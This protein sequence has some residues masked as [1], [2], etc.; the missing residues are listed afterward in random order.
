[1]RS[2][3]F[4]A[5]SFLSITS[6]AQ[7]K[8]V[9]FS[10][11]DLPV[12]SYG[13]TDT[14]FQK[15]LTHK[16]VASLKAHKIPAVGFVNETKVYNTEGLNSFQVRLLEH[17]AGQGLELGNHTFSHRDY[18]NLSFKEFSQDVLK[19]E[20]VTKQVLDRHGRTMRYFRHPFLHAGDSKAKSDSLTNFLTDHGY[21]IAP[22]TLDNEEYL[23]A[24]AYKRAGDKNDKALQLRIGQDYL[25][26]M[27]KK[28]EYFERQARAL[29]GRDIAHVLLIHANALNADHMDALARMF[30]KHAYDFVSMEKA[31]EDKAYKTEVTVFG[32][33]GISWIDRWA[34]SQG[35]KGGFFKDEPET[36][37]YVKKLAE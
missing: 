30:E 16:L 2:L 22:V 1:M 5:A 29:F 32:K 36:P 26:Y 23:F 24:L 20:I 7:R 25:L 18:N 13:I 12:V 17:W 27:E 34:L 31:L 11:D 10:I 6:F 8:Q 33:W 19:G 21:T 35:K 28:L 14:S 9:C 37:A 15:D 4:I 3:V